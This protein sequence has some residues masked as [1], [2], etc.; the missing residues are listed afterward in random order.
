MTPDPAP[1]DTPAEVP[2]QDQVDVQVEELPVAPLDGDGWSRLD[3]RKLLLDPVR[4]LKE[5]LFPGLIAIFGVSQSNMTYWPLIIPLAI[6]APIAL[7]T[8]P[9]LTTYFRITDSQVQLR[10][11]LLNKRSSTAPLDRVR[12]VDL[13]ASLLHRI[14][15]LE[16]VQIGTG[17]DDDRI[18]L[19]A[20]ARED[21]RQLRTT[22][23][24]RARPTATATA[25]DVD[26]TVGTIDPDVGPGVG[27]AGGTGHEAST[28]LASI[29]WS[30]LR[31][32]PFSLGRLVLL[33][34]AIGVLS[35]FG[36]NLPIFS[37]DSVASAWHWI[38]RFA[39]TMVILVAVLSGLALWIVVA[40]VGYVIQWWNF[41]LVRERDSL[42]LTYGLFTTR[43]ISVEEAKVRG[44]QIT[45]PALLR[46][47][48][49]A[50]LA[51]L[52][53][54]VEDGV[55]EVLPPCPRPVAVSVG[56]QILRSREPLTQ[57]LVHHG[58][59]ARRRAY[60]AQIRLALVWP[61]AAAVAV[62]Q[63]WISLSWLVAVTVVALALAAVLAEST[64]RHLGH[65]LTDGHLVAGSGTLARIRTVLET[66]GIIGWVFA[67]SWW[68][69][70]GRLTDLVATTAAGSERVIIHD[71]PLATAVALANA[72]TPGLL[73][74]FLDA[75]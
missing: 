28:E 68:Q 22:L 1:V 31:F 30:W 75:P 40:V 11:G 21:A 44:V 41:R 3:A 25:E 33:A 23:L 20:L 42:H 53:T 57:A 62:W 19:D 35:Q 60:F 5:F 8:I 66:D 9:W 58:F 16:K 55:T 69:R 45:E 38:G 6:L 27:P 37:E 72:A 15:G 12:S 73:T 47:V 46:I 13:E 26:A 50:G 7:G 64:Y 36:D 4:T 17:V 18:T 51:T 49:G 14:L 61:I 34:G 2:A 29:N 71:V 65:T 48:G 54:G 10:T 24:H 59:R 52:A 32:A 70:R 63:S 43:S 39:L 56:E 74:G 67:Q